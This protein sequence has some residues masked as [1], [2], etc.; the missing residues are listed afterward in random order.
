ME[1]LNFIQKPL[2]SIIITYYNM[3][4]YIN[5]CINSIQKQTYDRYE[6]IIVNDGSNEE[7]SKI[8]NNI[9]CAKII[10]L[11]ENEGQLCAL[12]EGLNEA[13][14]EFVCM[15]DADDILLPNYIKTLLFAHLN[16]N[17]ALISSSKGIINENGEL[18]SLNSSKNKIDYNEI[19]NLF[20]TKENFEVKKV[21]APFGL[22]SWNPSTSAMWRK[23]ALE[24]LK[25]YPDK[26]YWKCGADKV[27]F[28]LLHL[29]G[30]SANI[31]AVLFLYRVH[32]SNNFNSSNLSG[33]K[34]YLCEKTIGRLI[35]WNIKL[36]FDTLKMFF[37]HKGELIEQYNKLNYYKMLCRIIFCINF[38]VLTKIL[39]AIIHKIIF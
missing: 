15:I 4:K 28:S 17:F 31:D 20:K 18:L 33:D 6:I 30:S 25:Y 29:I 3:G 39:K 19:E 9:N 36:R 34:K 7:N 32:S 14:G 16:N 23:N 10:N 26:K 35:N 37:K 1:Q 27:I 21:K 13:K 12:Y 38:T 8:L 2:V 5:D 24:I 11:K 22:W